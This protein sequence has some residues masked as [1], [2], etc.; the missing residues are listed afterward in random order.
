MVEYKSCL[1]RGGGT[2][3]RAV[4]RRL[5]LRACRFNSCPRHKMRKLNSSF[6]LPEY[7]KDCLSNVPATILK[8]FDVKTKK[9]AVSQKYF[10][11]YRKKD[12]KNIVF[13]IIDAFGFYQWK[14]YGN[15]FPL[16]KKIDDKKCLYPITSVFPS[17]TASALNTIHSGLTPAE[18][19]L[20]EWTLYFPEI[21]KTIMT[22]PFTDIAV[23]KRDSLLKEKISPKILFD[24]P[25]IYQK[26]EKENINCFSFLSRVYVN[27]CY[28][29]VARKGSKAYSFINFSDLTVKLRNRLDK[30]K[31]RNFFSVYW[32]ELDTLSH[33]YGPDS[34]SCKAELAKISSLLLR[35]FIQKLNK[36]TRKET[37]LIISADHG[38]IGINPKEVIYLNKDKF[39]M[40]SLKKDKKGEAILPTGGPRSVLLHIKKNKLDDVFLYLKDKLLK[41]ADILL[42]EEAIKLNLFG[43]KK[44]SLRFRKRLGDLLILPHKNYTIWREYKGK[45]I[46]YLGHHGGLSKEE[47]VIP[48]AICGLDEL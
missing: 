32:D 7:K 26:L 6:I 15:K 12:Y 19:G 36:K 9:P 37:L 30:A 34:D 35:E 40:E 33:K 5:C 18:H 4:L 39:V 41:K 1:C 16:F 25:T 2:G 48:L 14:K 10:E 11:K 46:K 31:G 47:M 22:L 28:A 43:K 24:F 8:L 21:D 20:F 13:F 3:R 29:K 38:Q 44:I 17:T 45:G 27:G 23:G 42:M